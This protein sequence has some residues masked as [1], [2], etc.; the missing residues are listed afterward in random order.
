MFNLRDACYHLTFVFASR[1]IV[2]GVNKKL[3][4]PNGLLFA[5]ADKKTAGRN[6]Q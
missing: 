6:R 5:G 2:Y 3:P 1:F 4:L